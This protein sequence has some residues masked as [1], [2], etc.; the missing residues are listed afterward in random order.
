MPT[1]MSMCPIIKQFRATAVT[2]VPLLQLGIYGLTAG[3]E[4]NSF[5]CHRGPRAKL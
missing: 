2:K 4:E 3:K 5:N 1:P